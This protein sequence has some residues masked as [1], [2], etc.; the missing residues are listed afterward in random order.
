VPL[1]QFIS[2]VIMVTKWTLREKPWLTLGCYNCYLCNF[3]FVCCRLLWCGRNLFVCFEPKEKNTFPSFRSQRIIFEPKS[4]NILFVHNETF[5]SQR[6][7]TAL[8]C[9]PLVSYEM[10][11]GAMKL[12]MSNA[13]LYE[14]KVWCDEICKCMPKITKPTQTCTQTLHLWGTDI[15]WVD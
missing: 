15:P 6:R 7:K 1:A 12:Q 13:C 10:H 11:H 3:T 9:F 2:H 14:C 5:L 8:P 4:K